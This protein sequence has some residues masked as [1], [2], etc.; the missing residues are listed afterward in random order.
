MGAHVEQPEF[1][2]REEPDRP[3]ADDQRIGLD[4]LVHDP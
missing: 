4:D 3:G 2:H 1:E